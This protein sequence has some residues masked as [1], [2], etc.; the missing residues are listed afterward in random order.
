LTTT[1]NALCAAVHDRMPVILSPQDYDDWLDP[2][3]SS[4][5]DL[6]AMLKPYTAG[7][8]VRFPVTARLNNVQNDDPHCCEAVAEAVKAAEVGGQG[9]LFG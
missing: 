2:G 7:E 6:A 1:P 3:F 4:I 9:S 8:M 5:A